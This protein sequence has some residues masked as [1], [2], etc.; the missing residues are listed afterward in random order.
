MKASINEE[1]SILY[2]VFFVYIKI[3]K[4]PFNV[5]EII[6]THMSVCCCFYSMIIAVII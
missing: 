3:Q 2:T 1:V 4:K 6:A 5:F